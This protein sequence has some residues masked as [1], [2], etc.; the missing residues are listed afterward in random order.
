[1]S[2]KPKKITISLNVDQFNAIVSALTSADI[3]NQTFEES[4][5]N[6]YE[7]KIWTQAFK[8]FGLDLTEG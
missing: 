6:E 1:M 3:Y 4:G 2:I 7:Q 8:K 5:L